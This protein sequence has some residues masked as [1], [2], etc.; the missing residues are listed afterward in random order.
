MSSFEALCWGSLKKLRPLTAKE[1]SFDLI[2]KP[3]KVSDLFLVTFTQLETPFKY[4]TKFSC[5]FLK[6]FV[7]KCKLVFPR[8]FLA[9]IAQWLMNGKLPSSHKSS[10]TLF[11]LLTVL[12]YRSFHWTINTYLTL[13]SVTFFPKSTFACAVTCGFFS[14]GRSFIPTWNIIWSG[15]FSR[16]DGFT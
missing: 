10:K 16:I 11:I 5:Y 8:F 12:L 13:S 3:S 2:L 14:G 9:S 15:L 6:P 4:L 1:D 7:F